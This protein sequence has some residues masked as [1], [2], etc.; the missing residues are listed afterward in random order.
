MESVTI[1]VVVHFLVSLALIIR[2]LTRPHREPASRIAW[3][4]VIATLPIV[5]ILA[6]VFFG[7]VNIGRA[8]ADSRRKIV[9]DLRVSLAEHFAS[10]DQALAHVPDRYQHLFAAGKSVSHFEVT[11]GNSA[12]LLADSNATIDAMVADID[13]ATD[14]V[15]LLFYIW[16]PD[17]NGCKMVDALKRAAARGVTCRAMADDL[18]SR[19]MIGSQHWSDMRAAGVKLAAALPIGHPLLRIIQGRLD[20]RNHRKIL[21]ID[22]QITYCGS[23]NCADPEFLVKAKYAPWVD[24]VMRFVGPVAGQNQYLFACDWIEN[25]KEDLSDLLRNPG[26]TSAAGFPAQVIG[27]GPTVRFSAM[28]EIFES[29]FHAA[30]HELVISTPYFVPNDSTRDALCAAAYRGVETTIIF[31]AKND[32]WIVAAASRSYYQDLL[33]AGV[34]IHEYV[35]GLLHAKTLTIDREVLLIGSANMDRRSFDLN[36]ENNILLV[37]TELTEQLRRRQQQYIDG[38]T[39]VTQQDVASWSLGKRLWNN[40]LA[41]IGP[42]L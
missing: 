11:P 24:T 31:P 40:T 35:G 28:P 4:A 39:H 17:H 34:R 2:V 16:L 29:L 18:G 3:I 41:T 6:Y 20:L 12:D 21:V 9:D 25:T 19:T 32:S 36:Y 13:A 10:D 23:Q 1:G 38:S 37:D 33:S 8:R 14:H 26:G 42:I 30:R 7:E 15:H 5:G 22:G 27:T